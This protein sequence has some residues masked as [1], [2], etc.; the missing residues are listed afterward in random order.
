MGMADSRIQLQ[1]GAWI[2]IQFPHATR[3]GTIFFEI[4][5][6][7]RKL[8]L[9]PLKPGEHPIR[10][11]FQENGLFYSIQHWDK[12]DNQR[13]VFTYPM[14]HFPL[15]PDNEDVIWQTWVPLVPEAVY[16]EIQIWYPVD[17]FKPSPEDTGYLYQLEIL[18]HSNST[19]DGLLKPQ[20]LMKNTSR[21]TALPLLIAP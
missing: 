9:L 3:S 18:E 17:S 4:I 14:L 10:E 20:L 16:L 7:L 11:S 1:N 6:S 19:F 15:L 2:Q 21:S 12:A 13:P 8:P 5:S